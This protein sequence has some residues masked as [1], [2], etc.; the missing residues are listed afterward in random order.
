[1]KIF[2]VCSKSFYYKIPPI[3]DFLEKEGHLI[4]LPNSYQHPEQESEYRGTSKHAEWKATMF[5]HSEEVIRD[6]DAL[7]VLNYSKNGIENYIGGATFLEMYEAFKENKKIYMMNN[8]PEGIL[9]DEIIGFNPTIIHEN[10]KK[11]E[12]I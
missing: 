6:V 8:I 11:I 2:L 7:L 5:K 12:K 10:L 4:I 1:M 9:K 3:Q